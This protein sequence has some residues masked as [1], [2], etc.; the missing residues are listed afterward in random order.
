MDKQ[1]AQSPYKVHIQTYY[2]DGVCRQIIIERAEQETVS[3][4]EALRRIIAEW[5]AA[6]NANSPQ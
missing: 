1:Q 4:S 3:M 6:Q 5:A 2:L